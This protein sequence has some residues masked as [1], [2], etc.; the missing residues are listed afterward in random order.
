MDETKAGAPVQATSQLGLVWE[1]CIQLV[2]P[3]HR[4]RIEPHQGFFAGQNNRLDGLLLDRPGGYSILRDDRER[5]HHT[6][7]RVNAHAR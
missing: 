3:L 5:I 6:Y 1:K 2:V 4:R 7:N